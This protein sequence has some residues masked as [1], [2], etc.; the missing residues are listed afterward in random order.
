[1][2]SARSTK[3]NISSAFL[4]A[5]LTPLHEFTTMCSRVITP[6]FKS[7]TSGTSTLVG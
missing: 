1:M 3:R 7:G 2:L 5:P 4:P 6:A